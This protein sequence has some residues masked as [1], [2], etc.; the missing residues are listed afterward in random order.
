MAG[1]QGSP[2]VHGEHVIAC[3]LMISPW[4][5]GRT[6]EEMCCLG[7]PGCFQCRRK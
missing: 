5:D 2:L 7:F 6:C 1:G 3:P 4:W